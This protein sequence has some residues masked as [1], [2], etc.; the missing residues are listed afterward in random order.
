M[1]IKSQF[2]NPR[3]LRSFSEEYK[4]LP[5]TLFWDYKPEREELK[6][7]PCNIFLAHEPNQFFGIQSWLIANHHAF[8]MVLSWD[9][10]VLKY[11]T[12]ALNFYC[13][14]MYDHEFI[15][16]K[17]EKTFEVSYLSGVKAITQGHL[18]RQFL[19]SIKEEIKIPNKWF[20][21]LDDFDFE[22]NVRPGYSTYS[23]DVSHIPAGANPETYGKQ[24]LYDSMF[25]VAVENVRVNNW[26]TEK[27]LQCF[28]NKTVPIYWGCPN[29][30]DLGY[31]LNG[32]ITFNTPE[33]LVN[34]INNL[35]PED[36][37][38]RKT[39]IEH[40]YKIAT[41][42]TVKFKLGYIINQFKHLNSL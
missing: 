13:G 6:E 10:Q 40:N 42:D 39:A 25:H 11:C 9:E 19:Y 31:D 12:N 38:K 35:T 17:E 23:K 30:G 24:F 41:Q 5:I 22:T 1:V 32:I 33:E 3:D 28:L 26:Y 18:L 2:F 7:N 20:K 4:D 16:V 29:I 34:K 8:D 14:W 36:Y 37:N 21:V 27:I 15:T